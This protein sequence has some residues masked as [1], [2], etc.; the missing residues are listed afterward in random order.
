MTQTEGKKQ[1]R[2]CGDCG[3][4]LAE[5]DGWGSCR[6]HAPPATILGVIHSFPD[7]DPDCRNCAVWPQTDGLEDGC[8][9]SLPGPCLTNSAT[10]PWPP[11]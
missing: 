1:Y 3:A 10:V 4:W 11:P 5:V 6:R 8:L 2:S 7:D 9:E